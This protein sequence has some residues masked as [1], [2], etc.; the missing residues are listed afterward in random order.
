MIR[1]QIVCIITVKQQTNGSP[2]VCLVF[3]FLNGSLFEDIVESIIEGF[4][5]FVYDWSPVRNNCQF[6]RFI[7]LNKMIFTV[8]V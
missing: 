7:L 3:L 4:V 8:G 5:G 6:Q 1:L 2:L